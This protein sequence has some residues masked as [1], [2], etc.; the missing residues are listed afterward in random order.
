MILKGCST[1]IVEYNRSYRIYFSADKMVDSSLVSLKKEKGE[2]IW[3]SVWFLALSQMVIKN[4][5]KY[6]KLN[7]FLE[8][9]EELIADKLN[10]Q[11][12][13]YLVM[14]F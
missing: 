14:E 12:K 11:K 3:C 6:E 2:I 7:P 9:L 1:F 5:E 10:Y 13:Q 8:L 4:V